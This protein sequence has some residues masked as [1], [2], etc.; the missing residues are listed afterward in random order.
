MIGYASAAVQ[1]VCPQL[2]QNRLG[3]QPLIGLD[4]NGFYVSTN[5]FPFFVN[6][7]SLLEIRCRSGQER[8]SLG[9][10]FRRCTRTVMSYPAADERPHLWVLPGVS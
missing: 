6:G 10:L 4:T 2:H 8:W 5:E 7:R 1:T 3:D 9:R